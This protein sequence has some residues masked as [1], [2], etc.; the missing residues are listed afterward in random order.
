LQLET[1]R[2]WM[3][4]WQT[5]DWLC[6]RPIAQDPE[7]MRYIDSG[8]L[9]SDERTRHFV[10]AQIREARAYGFCLWKLIE[11]V[12]G[13]LIGFC[14]LQH[15]EGEIEIGWWLAKAYW[16][17]GVATEAARVALLDAFQRANLPRIIAM[18]QPGNRAS[19]H[20]M[21]KLGMRFERNAVRNGI[22]V[23]VY[24]IVNEKLPLAD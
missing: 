1:E 6:F 11:K 3:T 2:L 18:A 24:G 7:V 12:T 17:K 22:N 10:Q 23:V 16:G 19:I 5:A 21:E 8:E 15:Y 13:T 14:G 20:I 4:E 9:W